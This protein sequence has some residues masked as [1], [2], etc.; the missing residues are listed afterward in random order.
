MSIKFTSNLIFDIYVKKYLIENI[1]F[2]F[3]EEIEKIMLEQVQ[4]Q[5]KLKQ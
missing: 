4:L 5:V 3:K 1:D 2:S